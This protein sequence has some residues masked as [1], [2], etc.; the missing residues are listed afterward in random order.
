MACLLQAYS[1][2]PLKQMFGSTEYPITGVFH[3][4][5]KQRYLGIFI[6]FPLHRLPIPCHMNPILPSKILTSKTLKRQPFH[7]SF[8][9]GIPPLHPSCVP[10]GGIKV[11][12]DERESN[13]Q[14]AWEGA[15]WALTGSACERE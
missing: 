1:A 4:G 14:S 8:D 5:L 15:E 11:A 9:S 3:S 7:A 6:S 13:N 12:W 2:D 10:S